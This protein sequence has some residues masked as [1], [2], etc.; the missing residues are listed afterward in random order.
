MMSIVLAITLLSLIVVLGVLA[1]VW[2]R[3][4]SKLF[5]YLRE[6]HPNEYEILGR[7]SI[8]LNN[9]PRNSIAFLHFITSNRSSGIQDSHL[10][11][12][13]KLLSRLLYTYLA[14]FMG[15]IVLS[16]VAAHASS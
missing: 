14:I 5:A 13:C 9:S 10:Q 6:N 11:K 12:W 3:E 16:M 8:F 2:F 7:P 15:L 1:I 4:V